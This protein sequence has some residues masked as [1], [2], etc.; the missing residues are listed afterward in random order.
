MGYMD[1]EG[2]LVSS[3]TGTPMSSSP[4]VF[5]IYPAEIDACFSS[6]AHC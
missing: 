4:A 3:P 2:L 6:T 5:N 1:E